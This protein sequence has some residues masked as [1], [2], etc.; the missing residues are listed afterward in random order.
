MMTLP[1]LL[2]GAAIGRRVRPLWIAAPLAYLSHFALDHFPHLEPSPEWPMWQRQAV[3][4]S[5]AI[6]AVMVLAWILR[7]QGPQW[8]VIALC[9]F[10]ADWPDIMRALPGVTPTLVNLP[11]WRELAWFHELAHAQTPCANWLSGLSG[12]GLVCGIAVWAL[13]PHRRRSATS[14]VT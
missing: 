10:L 3:G 5:E 2:A 6:I 8:P 4:Y 12:Q 13:F 9:A 1:H 14:L 11:I 7:R